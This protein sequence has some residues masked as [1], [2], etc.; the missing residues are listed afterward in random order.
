LTDVFALAVAF[1]G[2]LATVYFVLVAMVV[3][4]LHGGI[5]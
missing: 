1:T 5:D 2:F 3:T 4:S